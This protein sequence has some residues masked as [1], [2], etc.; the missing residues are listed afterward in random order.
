MLFLPSVHPTEF[1]ENVHVVPLL[2]NF[3]TLFHSSGE[4]AMSD[5]VEEQW[6][7]FGAPCERLPSWPSDSNASDGSDDE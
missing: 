7:F 1:P 6:E 5:S 4:I 2:T 3:S